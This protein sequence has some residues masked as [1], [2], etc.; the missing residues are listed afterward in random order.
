M[1]GFVSG[2][3]LDLLLLDHAFNAPCA[4]HVRRACKDHEVQ[5]H[6]ISVFNDCERV[7]CCVKCEHDDMNVRVSVAPQPAAPTAGAMSTRTHR[8]ATI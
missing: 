8:Y 6:I 1:A 3:T 5:H 7:K 2:A 4:R